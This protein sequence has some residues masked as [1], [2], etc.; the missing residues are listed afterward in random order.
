[1]VNDICG[2]AD[3]EMPTVCTEHDAAVVKMASPPDLERP[4][5]VRE[6]DWAAR[7][8]GWAD[9]ADYVDQVFEAL[10]Q[11]GFTEKTIVDPAFGGG[12][13]HRPWRTIG[14]RFAV[15]ES[16]DR[17]SGRYSS[18]STE[19]TSLATSSTGKRTSASR[20]SG[21][22]AARRRTRRPRHTDA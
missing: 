5:A 1:M 4:G 12:A 11:N 6:T 2:F 8:P 18:R 7:N 10:K 19:R 9:R 21:G 16:L 17:S 14:K 20:E 15:L 22:D 3:P 13:R